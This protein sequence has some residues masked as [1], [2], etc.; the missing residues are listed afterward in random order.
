MLRVLE[1][2][3]RQRDRRGSSWGGHGGIVGYGLGDGIIKKRVGEVYGVGVS[4]EKRESVFGCGG[5]NVGVRVGDFLVNEA[6][7]LVWMCV[8]FIGGRGDVEV[9]VVSWGFSGGGVHGVGDGAWRGYGYR[10]A[11]G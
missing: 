10:K 1:G 4:W 8:G 9:V 5:G 3:R 7:E 2:E 6:S 11:G